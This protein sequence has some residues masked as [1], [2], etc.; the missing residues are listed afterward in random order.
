MPTRK[1]ILANNYCYHIINR[2]IGK[3][4]IFKD[5]NDYQRALLN[6]DYYRFLKPPL[7][8]SIFNKLPI[9]EKQEFIKELY[10]QQQ[11]I[12]IVSYC[13]MPNHIHFLLKQTIDKGISLFMSHWQN[14]Y[15]RYFNTKYKR[16]GYLFEAAFVGKLIESDEIL[17]HISRYIHLNPYTA[18][19]VDLEE[20]IKY[21]WSSFP[22]YLDRK[23]LFIAKTNLILSHF[24]GRKAYKNFVF[25]QSAYQKK[26]HKI[27]YLL[28][29]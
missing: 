24:K 16:K 18:S 28:L 6:I 2:G 17:Y 27:K 29:E 15:A 22:E 3:R 14:S 11:L 5:K 23:N 1:I 26:L 25:N 7:K 13:L 4:V 8:F 19:L 9:K 20:L 10:K 21:P 12:E